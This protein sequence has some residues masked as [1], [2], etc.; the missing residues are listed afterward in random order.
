MKERL[1]VIGGT[2]AGLSAAS[3]AKRLSPELEV[4]VFEQSGYVSY[5]ACG[6]PYFVGDLIKNPEDLIAVSAEELCTK[7]QIPTFIHHRVTN[8]NRKEKT[9]TVETVDD[10]DQQEISVHSYDKLVIA[11]GAVPIRPDI[12]GVDADGVYYLRTVEDGIRLKKQAAGREQ[13]AA[14][15]GGG[16][17]GLEVAEELTRVG[18]NVHL[19]EK[20]DRLLPFLDPEFSQRVKEC[21]QENGVTV[22]LNADIDALLTVAGKVC[23]VSLVTGEKQSVDFVLMSIGVLPASEL[24]R[25]AGIETGLKGGIIVDDT[26]QT[27]DASIWACGDCVLTKHLV[28]GEPV[29]IPLG[30]TANKQ[31]KIAGENI[32]GRVS[33]FPGVLGSM[34]T[35]VFGLTI[36]AT[37][38]SMAQALQAGYDAASSVITKSDRASYY[39]GGEPNT[40]CLIIDRQNG[41]LLGAQGIGSD[42]V[43]GRINVLAAAITAGMTVSCI[44][45]L[46]LVYAPP[47]APVY[48]PILIAAGQAV[49]KVRGN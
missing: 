49:K 18:T 28:T 16:F 34:V 8:I 43:A 33:V 19:Y 4:M 32:A 7:R 13:T 5:G 6:L 9:V 11:T 48:D 22:H 45:E 38:L 25:Q 27:G 10:L 42:S 20:L 41:K 35:K 36:A 47:V 14:I 23:G 1:I 2:A 26:M 3:K 30:T 21:L 24:A 29:Y 39:P 44:S 15:V 31:G 17:I 46:D 12:P 40:I 37:G